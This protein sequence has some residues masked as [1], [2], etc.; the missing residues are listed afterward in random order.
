MRVLIF[1]LDFTLANT[2]ECLPYLTS[3]GGRGRVVAAIDAGEISVEAYDPRLVTSFN[4]SFTDEICAVIVSDSPRPYCIKVLAECGYDIDDRYV[5]GAQGKPMVDFEVIVDALEHVLEV[6]ADELEFLV[7]GDSPKDIYFAHGIQAPS[8]FATWGTRHDFDLALQSMPTRVAHNHTQLSACV[9]EFLDGELDFEY[10]DFYQDFEFLDPEDVERVELEEI[11]YVKEYVS[12]QEHYR[13]GS[14]RWASKDLHWIVKPAK[15][16]GAEH[17]QSNRVMQLYGSG[18]VFNTQHSLR[19]LAGIY[20]RTFMA[21]LDEQ[22]VEGRV[23]IVPVPPSVPHE[24]N[25]SS[26]IGLIS[27]WWSEWVTDESEDI[28]MSAFDVV[29]RIVPKHPSHDTPGPRHMDDQLPTLGLL[30]DS[31]FDED[32]DYVVILDDVVTSG[33]H[34]NAVASIMSSAE[35]VPGDPVFLG[36]ALFKTV[37]PELTF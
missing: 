24:C 7:V 5:F 30:P 33:S 22:G 11:G 25:L 8:V 32:V 13:G 26:P 23:L 17:H 16:Y 6:D 18:G 2:E 14:D 10:H 19:A 36:F 9:R 12:K 15:N 3:N 29:R 37:H 20:K 31:Q 35:I 1:D 34:M 27:E 21:W 28:E 4:G